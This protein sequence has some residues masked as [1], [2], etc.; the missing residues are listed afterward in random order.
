MCWYLNQ[1]S[2]NVPLDVIFDFKCLRRILKSDEPHVL[3]EIYRLVIYFNKH[4]DQ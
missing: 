3:T 4:G 2:R 1:V